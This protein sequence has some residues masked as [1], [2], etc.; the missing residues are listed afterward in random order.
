M[1]YDIFDY[2]HQ[3]KY[4]EEHVVAYMDEVL[5]YKP[6]GFVFKS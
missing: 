1:K 3:T 4:N 6:E 2:C 5:R